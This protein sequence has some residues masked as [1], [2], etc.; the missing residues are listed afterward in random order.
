MVRIGLIFFGLATFATGGCST[1]TFAPLTVTVTEANGGEPV[2]MA[3]VLAEVPS[4]D[5]PFSVQTI[6]GET[7]PLSHSAFTNSDG[8]AVVQYA[9]GRPVRV[10]VLAPRHS[11][12]MQMIDEPWQGRVEM[13]GIPDGPEAAALHVVIEP[14]R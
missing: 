5:H 10:G 8:V 13:T 9:V 3:K 14:R 4:K 2:P 12:V 6:F 7:G 11:L 1:P